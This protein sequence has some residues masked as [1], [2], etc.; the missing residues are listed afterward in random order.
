MIIAQMLSQQI[1]KAQD[2]LFHEQLDWGEFPSYWLP[3]DKPLLSGYHSCVFGTALVLHCLAQVQGGHRLRGMR[4]KAAGFLLSERAPCGAWRYSAAMATSIPRDLDDTSCAASALL[5]VGYPIEGGICD[6]LCQFRDPST[7]LFRTWME[8]PPTCENDID[9]VVNANVLILFTLL[10]QNHR[11]PEV[12]RFMIS[13]SQNMCLQN[14]QVW[15]Y[16]P[17]VFAYSASRAYSKT[18]D[19]T[20]EDMVKPMRDFLLLTQSDDGSWSTTMETALAVN[21]LINLGYSGQVI[22]RAIRYL[23]ENQDANDGSWPAEILYI[24]PSGSKSLTTSFCLEALSKYALLSR[25]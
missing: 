15:Y 5:E 23:V 21:T 7:G 17:R 11:I 13:E 14:S 4:E 2:F 8:S 24:P 18:V 22:D 12:C 1:S 19:Q 3:E 9:S 6:Y 25:H 16:S 10:G 20:M